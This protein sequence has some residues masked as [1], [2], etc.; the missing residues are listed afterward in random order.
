MLHCCTRTKYN[1]TRYWNNLPF[2]EEG[3]WKGNPSF[4]YQRT[5]FFSADL[6]STK[7]KLYGLALLKSVGLFFN[8]NLGT[9]L[10]IKWYRQVGTD[11]P[12]L[13][14]CQLQQ[15]Q[16]GLTDWQRMLGREINNS[17]KSS[18]SSPTWAMPKVE[19]GYQSR[20]SDR[21][22][23]YTCIDFQALID[24]IWTGR[25]VTGAIS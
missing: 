23:K 18:P 3:F 13:W 21:P 10:N 19:T 14:S 22:L 16:T 8:T 2:M 25:L 9:Y 7:P 12:W 11:V 24:G 15:M 17:P 4:N 1:Y 5:Y 6:N 20:K